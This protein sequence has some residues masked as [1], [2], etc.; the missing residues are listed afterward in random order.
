MVRAHKRYL[1]LAARY[2]NDFGNTKFNVLQTFHEHLTDARGLAMQAAAGP[3]ELWALLG[4]EFSSRPSLPPAK[5]TCVRDDDGV[6]RALFAYDSRRF[7]GPIN[8][9]TALMTLCNARNAS[10]ASFHVSPGVA[11][12]IVGSR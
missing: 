3:E 7:P 1:Q 8:P 10:Q 5:R 2:D 6:V 12:K 11:L 9:K 4:L